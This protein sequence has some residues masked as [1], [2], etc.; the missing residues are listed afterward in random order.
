MTLPLRVGVWFQEN[1]TPYGGPGLVLS[2]T[3][4]GLYQYA[5]QSGQ[6]IIV[7]LNELG[8]VNWA[9]GLTASAASD[10]AKMPALWTGPACFNRADAVAKPETS[11]V[12]RAARNAL[13]PSVWFAEFVNH[14]LPYAQGA[15]GR[16]Q[17][18]WPAGVDTDFFTPSAAEKTQD[19]FIYFKSQNFADLKKI[20]TYLFSNWFGIKGTVLTYYNYDPAM[21]RDTARRS[22]FCIMLDGT[23][24]QGLAALEIMACDCPLFVL[25]N[26]VCKE[27]DFEYNGA[28]SVTNMDR[29]CGSKSCLE[30]IETD[31]PQFISELESYSPRLFVT[32]DYSYAAAARR[33]LSI[34]I[35]GIEHKPEHKQEE[36][37]GVD[38]ESKDCRASSGACNIAN[39]SAK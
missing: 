33:L 21:L 8:D 17:T 30:A 12:W 5:A 38:K 13:F 34:L 18:I 19:Y 25:D 36:N 23:E 10:A 29:R 6:Q 20:Q 24:T 26:T 39:E 27:G 28:T 2:G 11:E 7:L 15:E 22:K 14:G 1:H 35:T 9:L 3:I 4:L 37:T 32:Q 31:F 16:C